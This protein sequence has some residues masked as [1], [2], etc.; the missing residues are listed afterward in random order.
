MSRTLRVALLT[1][2]RSWRGSGVSLGKI[3]AAL[4]ARGH[5]V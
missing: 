2:A 5:E 4:A 3:G 1:S